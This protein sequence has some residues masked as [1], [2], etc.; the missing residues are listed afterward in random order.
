[1]ETSRPYRPRVS[2]ETRL[3]LTAGVMAV[4]ALWLLARIRFPERPVTP[5]PVPSVLSQLASGPKYDDLAGEIAQLHARLQPSLLALDAPSTVLGSLQTSPRTTAIRL[6][7][8]LAVTLVP[9]G[10]NREQWNDVTILV[11]DAASGLAVVHVPIAV[12]TSPPVPWTP[13]QPQ[14]PRYFVA[15]DVSPE[16]VSLRPVFVGSLNPVDSPLWSEPVW[17]V[18]G[19]TD[20]AP[21]SFLFTSSAE[22]AGLVTAHGGALA[23]VPGGTVL[24]EAERLLA[25]PPGP[26]GAIG[27]EVQNLTPP[28][29]S[30]TGAPAGVVVTWVDADG[31]GR[32]QLMTGDVIEAVD[33]RMLATRQHWDVRVARLSVGETLSLRVRRRGEIREVALVANAPAAQ[34][35]SRSLGLTLRARPKIGAE[36]VRI[37][38]GSAADRAGLALGDVITLVVDVSAPTPAQVMRSYTSAAQGERVMVAV[39]R[40]DAHFVTTLER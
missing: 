20:L 3:L 33:G 23:I 36:V 9:S 21:G 4:A 5:N 15:S 37:E 13:R 39:T 6:R 22:L 26:A 31:A 8:D 34:P 24:A 16:G 35:A 38:R 18:P 28:V 32:E 12:P 25:T 29:A 30:V 1:M 7:D 27:I 10:S 14:Q 40:G 2:R 19:R 17:A 11:R